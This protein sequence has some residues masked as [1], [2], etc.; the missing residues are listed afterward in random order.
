MSCW[1]LSAQR[2]EKTSQLQHMNVTIHAM[3]AT[4]A[5]LCFVSEAVQRST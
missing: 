1:L 2:I 5:D 3:K 4:E